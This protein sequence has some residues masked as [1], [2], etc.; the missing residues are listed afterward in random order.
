MYT[1]P[2]TD[3]SIAGPQLEA[4]WV[5]KSIEGYV[6]AISPP[7]G[8]QTKPKRE[9]LLLPE[10]LGWNHRQKLVGGFRR[11]LIVSFNLSFESGRD[12]MH[13]VHDS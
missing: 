12:R 5:G 2:S 4:G 7:Y 9:G 11:D 10:G 3:A 1:V 13:V 8:E 6:R